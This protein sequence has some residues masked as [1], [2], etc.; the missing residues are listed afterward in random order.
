M[1]C[2]DRHSTD[3]AKTFRGIRVEAMEVAKNAEFKKFCRDSLGT[4][5][6]DFLAQEC[7]KA[8]VAVT[9]HGVGKIWSQRKT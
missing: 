7:A 5:I 4:A 8:T 6:S 3:E 9:E 1:Y 2:A